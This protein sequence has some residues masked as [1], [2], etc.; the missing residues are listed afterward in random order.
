MKWYKLLLILNLFFNTTL[1]FFLPQI[2]R[3]WHPIAINDKIDKTKP[4]LVN[5]GKLPL[6]LWFNQTT[7]HTTVGYCKH[8]GSKLEKGFINNNCLVCPNHLTQH[9][10]NDTIGT[11]VIKDGI[12]WWSYKNL[13]KSPPPLFKTSNN[14]EH[15][16]ID[17]NN[18]LQTIILEFMYSKHNIKEISKNNKFLIKK[19]S[20]NM[21]HQIFY[22]YPFY[23][24]GSINKKINYVINFL[25]LEEDRTRLFVNVDVDIKYLLHY[26][27]SSKLYNL[28]N[29]DNNKIFKFLLILKDVK[30]DN[31]LKKIYYLFD[32]YMFPNENNVYSF[33]K[34]R[35][36]Y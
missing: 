33:Y 29:Y 4:F 23:L 14:I 13:K 31:Y 17:V 1:S 27:L 30:N 21:E 5:Y 7:P 36:F 28:K 26:F 11:T 34:Y 16:Y 20:N 8:L 2:F 24:K 25:P 12:I 35:N 6:V 3:E 18:S 19:H 15:Y 10:S 9:T 22:K 32:K